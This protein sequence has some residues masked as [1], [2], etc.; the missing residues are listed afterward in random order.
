MTLAKLVREN[1]P[2]YQRQQREKKRALAKQK[3]EKQARSD[4]AAEESNKVH[5]SKMKALI[6]D[7]WDLR[8]SGTWPV[9][10]VV[11]KGKI[12]GSKWLSKNKGRD[13]VIRMARIANRLRDLWYKCPD[14]PVEGPILVRLGPTERSK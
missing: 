8:I 10:I 5:A 6:E 3:R 13:D 4:A 7:C 11:R 9:R 14:F 1:D 12:V 2:E